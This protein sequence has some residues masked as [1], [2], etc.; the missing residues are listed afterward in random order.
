[1]CNLLF[2]FRNNTLLTNFIN[3]SSKQI[4]ETETSAEQIIISELQ[5]YIQKHQVF[6]Q[7]SED[8]SG[9][10]TRSE[11]T[12]SQEL[13]FEWIGQYINELWAGIAERFKHFDSDGTTDHNCME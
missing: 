11:D 7:E 9:T 13:V 8:P 12:F 5:K 6:F 10:R 1:M 4:S 2:H 3:E